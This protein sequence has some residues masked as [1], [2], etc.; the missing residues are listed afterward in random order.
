[1]TVEQRDKMLERIDERIERIMDSMDLITDQRM[2]GLLD[3][4]EYEEKREVLAI[5][6]TALE[7]EKKL[8]TEEN[9]YRRN[10]QRT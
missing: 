2:I 9:D 10:N 1:M 7:L 6:R 5:G 4:Q 3:W 8:L